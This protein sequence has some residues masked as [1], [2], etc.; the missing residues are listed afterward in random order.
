MCSLLVTLSLCSFNPHPFLPFFS[1]SSFNCP[2]LP[3]IFPKFHIY[4]YNSRSWEVPWSGTSFVSLDLRSLNDGEPG[5]PMSEEKL[6]VPAQA[7]SKSAP[8]PPFVL[9]ILSMDWLMP[10][11]NGEGDLLYSPHFKCGSLPETPSQTYS[12]M[13]SS[14][15]CIHSP[16]ELTHK[17]NHCTLICKGQ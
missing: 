6:G 4:V 1:S 12:A 11:H 2:H 16:A 17:T 8:S 10:N 9:F 13:F 3:S 5:V 15:L 14:Y 7:E